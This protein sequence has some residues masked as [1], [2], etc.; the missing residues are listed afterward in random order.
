MGR[1]GTSWR[2]TKSTRE[3]EGR[4]IPSRVVGSVANETHYKEDTIPD[5]PGEAKNLYFKTHKS[6]KQLK[7]NSTKYLTNMG[8]GNTHVTF[9][10]NRPAHPYSRNDLI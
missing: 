8:R 6:L 7:A 5:F 9:G 10:L 1:R 3:G 4:S 2:L